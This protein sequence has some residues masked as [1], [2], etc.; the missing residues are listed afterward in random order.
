MVESPPGLRVMLG[1]P[2]DEA[3]RH[4]SWKH[5]V[6]TDPID[7]F[8]DHRLGPLPYRS[9]RFEPEPLAGPALADRARV[10]GK[11]GL[12]QAAMQVN[13]P[14]RDVPFTR[15]VEIKHATGQ[16]IDATTIV[17]ELPA[18]VEETCEPYYP[19]PA[20]DARAAFLRYQELAA[21]EP[22]TTFLGRLARYRY[23]NMD[24]VVAA[25]LHEFE[26]LAARITASPADRRG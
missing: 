19:V 4:F 18:E 6:F 1:T 8:F 24:Q 25:A 2:F 9:L 14:A 21:T 23:F 5:L 22:N 10:S 17:R 11:P 26:K 12:Y 16:I 20:P 15:I 3:R 13:F 7:A